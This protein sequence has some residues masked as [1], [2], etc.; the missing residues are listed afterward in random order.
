MSG[1]IRGSSILG[2]GCTNEL[3]FAASMST[4]HALFAEAGSQRFALP[5]VQVE[6]SPGMFGYLLMLNYATEERPRCRLARAY[7]SI[8]SVNA[9]S[10]SMT[11]SHAARRRS[12]GEI[13]VT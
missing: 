13:V 6:Q 4:V 3:R 2:Q 10:L 12:L 7:E 11:S 1:S 9:A 5:S 8:V